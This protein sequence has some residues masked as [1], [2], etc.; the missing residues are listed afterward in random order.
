MSVEQ[1][2]IGKVCI[3]TGANAG[4]GKATV[5]CLVER[6]AAVAMLARHK[7]RGE[8]ALEEIRQMSSACEVHLFLS[9]F[10]SLSSVRELAKELLVHYKKIHILINNAGIIPQTRTI[11]ED[12]FEMQFGVN[13]LA[14][15]LLTNLLLDRLRSSS[16]SR[17]INVSSG[18]HTGGTIPFGD[19]QSENSYHPSSVYAMTKLANVLFSNELAR[20]LNGTQVT[21]NSLHPGGV[22]TKLYYDYQSWNTWTE[23]E[24]SWEEIKRG[25][26][27]TLYLAISP[28][29]E[30]VS[31][32]YFSNQME[33]PSSRLSQDKEI[34]QRLWEVSAEM[35]GLT[36]TV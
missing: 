2:M 35:T 30:K 4:I 14:H 33:A 26:L 17:I 6:G 16:P 15:F 24:E 32:K 13:H 31:G 29:V 22:N 10:S 34:A 11:T 19:L 27:T 3:V 20:R 9:D 1:S 21:S 36:N 18:V 7:G 28:E 5:L 23:N 25:A 8:S 12:G